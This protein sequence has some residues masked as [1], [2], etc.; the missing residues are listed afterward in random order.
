MQALEPE[1]L[2]DLGAGAGAQRQAQATERDAAGK[3]VDGAAPAA[4]DP[5]EIDIAASELRLDS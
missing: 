3:G 5:E 1:P 4:Q 2:G